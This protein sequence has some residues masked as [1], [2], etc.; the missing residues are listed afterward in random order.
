MARCRG[1]ITSAGFDTAAEAAYHG[2][3]LVVIPTRNHY[4]QQCNAA[5]IERS[6]IGFTVTK[7]GKEM[8]EQMKPSEAETYRAWVDS[9]PQHLL[10]WVEE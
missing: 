5:D 4:E 8:L 1:L 3:P 6:G 9:A 10:K 7:I 2:I